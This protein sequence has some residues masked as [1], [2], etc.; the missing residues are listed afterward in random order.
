VGVWWYM[1]FPG[2]Q[3]YT[4]AA[5]PENNLKKLLWGEIGSIIEN[6]SDLFKTDTVTSLHVQRSAQSF[7]TGVTIPMSGTE[8]QREAK[9]S[10]KHASYLLFILDEGDAIPDE[11][12]SGIESCMSGGQG[13]YHS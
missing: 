3:V 9:F 2:S 4:A 10:G 8:A 13:R 6:H 5:P 12:Y 1:C 11:V 7:L